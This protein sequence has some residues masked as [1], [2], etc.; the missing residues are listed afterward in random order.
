MRTKHAVLAVLVTAFLYVAFVGIPVS[1]RGAR[2]SGG[3]PVATTNGDV[4][5]DGRIDITDAI[6]LL[7]YLFQHGDAPVPVACA[8]T[9]PPI[10]PPKASQIVNVQSKTPVTL[11]GTSADMYEVPDGQ[12]LVMTDLYLHTEGNTAASLEVLEETPD[13]KDTLR[14][15]SMAFIP[16]DIGQ[17]RKFSSSIGVVFGPKSK[18]KV[19]YADSGHISYNLSG[20]LT[21]RQ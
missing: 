13:G 6:Y 16:I 3:A 1:H 11:S 21:D 2:G 17:P 9:S 4:N 5:G 14:I 15:G 10:W 19:F 12:W 7:G 18:V 8:D 20:Y